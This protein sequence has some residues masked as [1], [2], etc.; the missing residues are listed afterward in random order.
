M[1]KFGTKLSLEK[2]ISMYIN[3][4][5]I[6]VWDIPNR[7]PRTAVIVH[8][9]WSVPL[10]LSVN[11]HCQN[12]TLQ[13]LKPINSPLSSTPIHKI[14]HYI[15]IPTAFVLK[16]S[17][18]PEKTRKVFVKR[19]LL[20]GTESAWQLVLLGWWAQQRWLEPSLGSMIRKLRNKW[21]L[22]NLPPP[23][24]PPRNKVFL[25]GL[26]PFLSALL[27][28]ICLRGVRRGR[29]TSHESTLHPECPKNVTL[30]WGR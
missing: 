15:H 22:V 3:W 23:N 9:Y 14:H 4:L 10:A 29:L 24:I 26:F 13:T 19:R 27:N 1:L 5:E 12:C 30:A 8:N 17:V 20:P 28:P 11:V 7:N 6:D 25:K 16:E 18:P 21:W 2:C